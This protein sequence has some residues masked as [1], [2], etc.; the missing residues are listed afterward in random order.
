V[1]HRLE[2]SPP[3]G[4]YFFSPREDPSSKAPSNRQ[5]QM[6]KTTF[7][8]VKN[9]AYMEIVVLTLHPSVSSMFFNV[10]SSYEQQF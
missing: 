6:T 3:D 4:P 5:R 7:D 8:R 1:Y 9:D 2:D 10:N